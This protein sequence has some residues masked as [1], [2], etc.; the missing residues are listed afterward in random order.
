M[1]QPDSTPSGREKVEAGVALFAARDELQLVAQALAPT[2]GVEI[3][4]VLGVKGKAPFKDVVA[5]IGG[6][7]RKAL[8]AIVIEEI[9][10][11]D[12]RLRTLGLLP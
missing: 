6:G 2:C 5:R 4:T 12:T 1:A 8:L 9:E 7:R 11:I 10:L 3:V